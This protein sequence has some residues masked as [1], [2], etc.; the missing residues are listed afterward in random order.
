M[1]DTSVQR[2]IVT[3]PL[4]R[5]ARIVDAAV[6]EGRARNLEPLTVAVLDAGGHLVAFQRED[7]SGVL[8]PDIAIG[9]AWGALGMGLSSR[10]IRDRTSDRPG[11]VTA[12]IAASG[13][14]FVPGPGGVLVLDAA[15]QVIGAVGVSGAASDLDEACAI[16][17]IRAAGLASDPPTGAL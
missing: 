5:A 17:G 10:T 11:F 14:R 6:A 12:A 13:G 2:L 4:A 3:L 15:G 1:A 8:R 9:K 7:G 16:A